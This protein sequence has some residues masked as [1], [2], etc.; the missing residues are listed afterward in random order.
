MQ[1]WFSFKVSSHSNQMEDFD[2]EKP[3]N[4]VMCV[5]VGVCMSVEPFTRRKIMYSITK[6]FHEIVVVRLKHLT[7]LK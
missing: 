4:D 2:T 7:V 6:S 3:R 1:F 5:C